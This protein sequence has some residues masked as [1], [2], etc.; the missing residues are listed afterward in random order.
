MHIKKQNVLI[1]GL[2]TAVFEFYYIFKVLQTFG[3]S[4]LSEVVT[5]ADAVTFYHVYS[6][7]FTLWTI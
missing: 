6:T 7:H 5:T 3:L 1:L 4:L 2:Y